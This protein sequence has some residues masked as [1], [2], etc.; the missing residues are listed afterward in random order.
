MTAAGYRPRSIM[1]DDLAPVRRRY[2][3]PDDVASCHTAVVEGY[4]IEGHV[5]AGDLTAL[6]RQRPRAIGLSVPGMPI[7]APGMEQPGG[8]REAYFTILLLP[9]G[10]RRTFAQH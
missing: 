8:A 1:V 2:H 4:A 5:P 10:R 3:V 7:G 6:L 9:D